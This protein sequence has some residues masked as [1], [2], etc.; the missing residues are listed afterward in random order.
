L[1]TGQQFAVP[2]RTKNANLWVTMLQ[3]FGIQANS[4]GVGDGAASGPI[5]Q[6]VR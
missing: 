3:G 2:A 5:A 4:F 6:M 1:K